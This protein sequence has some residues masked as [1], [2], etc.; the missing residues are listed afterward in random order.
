M[1]RSAFTMVELIF[2]IVVINDYETT[3]QYKVPRY[4]KIGY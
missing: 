4:G 1:K 2:V 3:A